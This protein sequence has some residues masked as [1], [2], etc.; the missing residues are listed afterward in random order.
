MSQAITLMVVGLYALAV[1]VIGWRGRKLAADGSMFN[2]FGRRAGVVR[3]SSGYL[4]LIG[5][6]ELITICQLGYDNGWDVFSFVGGIA[7]GFFFLACFSE[8]LRLMAYQRGTTTFAGYFADQFGVASS[9]AVAF[10]FILSLGSLLSIQ[11]IVGSDLISSV[12]GLSPTIAQL[13]MAGT[14]LAYLM[15]AGYVAVLSTDVLRAV[16]MSAVL[17]IIVGFLAN[18]TGALHRAHIAFTPLAAQDRI[19]YFVLGA[20]AVICAGDVWQTIFASKSRSAA[21]SS[22]VVGAFCFLFFGALIALIG[23]MT[24]ISV[25]VLP[26]DSSALIEATRHVLPGLLAPLMG[27]L[28]V[29]SVMATAD[30]EIWVIST[31]LLAW[32]FPSEAKFQAEA[33]ETEPFHPRLKRATK[34]VLPVVTL[35]AIVIA[36]LTRDAQALYQGMLV[37]L[38]SIAPV[39]ILAMF[40]RPSRA[41]VAVGLWSGLIAFLAAFAVTRGSIPANLTFLPPAVSFVGMIIGSLYSRLTARIV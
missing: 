25:P 33:S 12:T 19:I 30:T 6:G 5:G 34:S 8:R 24:K 10:T 22:L 32:K 35:L 7:A 20:F 15:A 21:S 27:L 36:F 26:A 9:T 29:G 37:L 11:F 40:T 41:S 31:S 3:A 17:L 4:S 16:F 13:F 28:V 1:F 14:I 2:I 38:T 23:I 39:V 18:S